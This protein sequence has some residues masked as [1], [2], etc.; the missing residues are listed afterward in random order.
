MRHSQVIVGRISGLY[1]V[2]GGMKIHSYTRPR[3]Q[4]FSYHPWLIGRAN[5]WTTRTLRAGQPH[6]K[7]L[8]A[9]IDGVADRDTALPLVGMDIAIHREQM[10]QLPEGEYYW[11]DLLGLEVYDL[12]GRYLGSI[13]EIEETGANDVL[14]VAQGEQKILIPLVMREVVQEV[15]LETGL[16]RVDWNPEYI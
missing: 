13:S 10:P 9:F 2:R 12:N 1:G 15:N 14:V 16:L 3:E 5:E 11:C 6:G 8:I 7:T 4:I